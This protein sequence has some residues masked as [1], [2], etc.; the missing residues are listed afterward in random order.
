MA[1]IST[2]PSTALV[3]TS[4]SKALKD[5][6]RVGTLEQTSRNIGERAGEAV[7]SLADS[8]QHYYQDGREYVKANPVKGVAIAAAAGIVTGGLI[9][10]ALRRNNQ[11]HTH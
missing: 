1:N 5:A 7:S 9:S 3:G 4:L 10:I 11:H 6:P 8:M 2:T